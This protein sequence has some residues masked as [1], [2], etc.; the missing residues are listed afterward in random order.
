MAPLYQAEHHAVY[1]EHLEAAVADPRTKNVALTGRYGTGKSS[2]LD[3][4]ERRHRG[5]VLRVSITTLGPDRDGEGLTNRIQKELVKQV[6]YRAPP[7]KLRTSQF[8][9]TDHITRTRALLQSGLFAALLGVVLALA[10]WLPSVAVFPRATRQEPVTA[11]DLATFFALWALF[12]LVVT[13]LMAWARRALGSRI[14]TSLSTAGTSIT[15]GERGDTYFDAYL[16]ELVTHFDEGQ[17]DFVIFEDID[18]FDDPVIFDSLRE[19]NTILTASPRR[20]TTPQIG[21]HL[22]VQQSQA[23]RRPD[24]HSPTVRLRLMAGTAEGSGD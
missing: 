23:M 10:G 1:L 4:F 24:P 19:L 14:I 20:L 13:I 16:E 6:I 22:S 12:F 5:K 2:V 21:C 7:D 11:G 9:R 15:L 17:E 3:E 8:A 18:R